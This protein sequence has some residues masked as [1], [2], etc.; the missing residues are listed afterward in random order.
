MHYGWNIE[1]LYHCQKKLIRILKDEKNIEER[2]YIK[3]ILET[4][5]EIIDDFKNN[6]REPLIDYND[7][8][9]AIERE[10]DTHKVYYELIDDFIMKIAGFEE[11]LERI[12]GIFK[13]FVGSDE[14]FGKY[15]GAT[16]TNNRAFSLMQ[17]FYQR[18]DPHWYPT[19]LN[20]YNARKRSVLFVDTLRDYN[21]ADSFYID[22][23]KR[24]FI[25]IVKTKDVSKLF[26]LVHEY[27][28]VLSYIANPKR[29]ILCKDDMY[30]EV[31]AVFPEMTALEMNVGKFDE[32][33]MAFEKYS[34]LITVYNIGNCLAMHLPYVDIW[35]DNNRDANEGFIRGIKEEFGEEIS[36]IDDSLDTYI[37][38]CGTYVMAYLVS[39]ELLH[40]YRTNKDKAL[41]IYHRLISLPYKESTHSFITSELVLGK[42]LEEE[43]ASMLDD[44]EKKL[45][46]VGAFHV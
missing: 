16:L 33:Q 44:F 37:N 28:H 27:G 40:M 23:L 15:T 30:D 10:L 4:L 14:S 6:G 9:S 46:K 32:T 3:K 13:P 26:T 45:L 35:K 18:F 19:F 41:D 36:D 25:E 29:Y 11:Q 31:P 34:S 12:E 20:A 7:R 17:T 5:E 43:T 22:I 1:D 21:Q 2:I 38:T 24:Y 8:L 42:N 39:I